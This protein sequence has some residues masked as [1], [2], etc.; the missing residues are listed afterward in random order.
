MNIITIFTIFQKIASVDLRSENNICIPNL[1]LLHMGNIVSGMLQHS[2]GDS[3]L[4]TLK[5]VKVLNVLNVLFV[6]L[7]RN[8]IVDSVQYVTY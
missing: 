2:I 3:Y 6:N 7:Y 1:A 4:T 5:G 8:V